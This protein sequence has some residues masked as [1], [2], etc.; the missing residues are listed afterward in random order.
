[1]PRHNIR[2]FISGCEAYALTSSEKT[3]FR[4]MQPWGLILFGRNCQSPSQLK[5]LT[6]EFRS[7]V[8]RKDAPVLIDQE[9]G[10]VQ[11]MSPT[12]GPWRKY[13]APAV[14]GRLYEQSPLQA[15]RAARNIGRLMASD[16]IE[17]GINVNCVPVLDMPQPD[18]HTIISDRA[19]SPKSEAAL[20]L[21]RAHVAGFAAGG[22]LPVVKHMPGHG[23]AK[24][25]SHQELPCV[26][27]S[28]QELEATDFVPFAAF[29]D[30]PM[31]M[32]CHIVFAAI[33]ND[34]PATHSRAIIRNLLRKQIGF[35]GL[36]ITDDLSMKALG[37]TYAERASRAF[38]AG[39]DVV[40]HC[41]G[42][43]D[44]MQE[45][46]EASPILARKSLRRARTA[47]R[48]LRRP[49]PFDEKAALKDLEAIMAA[50]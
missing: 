47:L 14:F 50:A 32:T 9:G 6:S 5:D 41:N 28:R 12:T 20:A 22:V 44:E 26:T 40:L 8:G 19:Y 3:F 31:A 30:A 45:V 17:A 33:D 49:L 27:A 42:H 39:C 1:M 13:P 4:E 11:R 48:Q 34:N 35:E 16:L 15:L 25:D 7:I 46:A 24:V 23:R 43:F 18:S 21:A 37:G 38:A 29:A 36:L 2:S 10:R